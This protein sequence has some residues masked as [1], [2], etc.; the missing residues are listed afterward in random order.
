LA[1][2]ITACLASFD[3]MDFRIRNC[4]RRARLANAT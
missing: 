4:K 1:D 2:E 3:V